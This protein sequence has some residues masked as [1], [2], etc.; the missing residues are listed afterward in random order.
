MPVDARTAQVFLCSFAQFRAELLKPSKHGRTS[1]SNA[2]LREQIDDIL[3]G[4]RKSQ[5]P[6]NGAKNDIAREAVVFEWRSMQQSPPRSCAYFLG[7]STRGLLKA[8]KINILY[9]KFLN[10]SWISL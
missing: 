5:V 9:F 6:A 1:N 8:R 3:V 10:S 7:I 4:Q 2:S